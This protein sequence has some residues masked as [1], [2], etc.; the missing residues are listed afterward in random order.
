MVND[1]LT[2]RDSQTES[3]L[4]PNLSSE[5]FYFDFKFDSRLR[6][7]RVARSLRHKKTLRLWS[8]YLTFKLN[9]IMRK[10]LFKKCGQRVTYKKG[11]PDSRVY[12]SVH[13]WPA[14]P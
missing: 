1:S 11:K 10:N 12:K 6:D 8:A 3:A 2:F 5:F 14:Y 9:F 7:I 4:S 13:D